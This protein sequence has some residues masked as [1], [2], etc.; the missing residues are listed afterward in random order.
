VNAR[1]R[2][3]AIATA[4]VLVVGGGWGLLI[5]PAWGRWQDAGSRARGLEAALERMRSLRD[6][7]PA[8]QE[9]RAALDARIGAARSEEVATAFIAELRALTKQAGFEPTTLRSLG[10]RP[11][12]QGEKKRGAPAEQAPFTEVSFE[13]KARTTLDKLTDLLVL[14]AGTPRP[15]RVVSLSLSPRQASPDLEIE[16]GLVAL[17]PRPEPPKER[18]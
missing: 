18:R 17:G 7:L 15:V 1:E 6:S 12:E 9:D 5:E 3:L 14:L 16:V 4:A 8:L 11:L 10:G 2:T 13:L